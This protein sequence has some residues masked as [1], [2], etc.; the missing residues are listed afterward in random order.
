MLIV[1]IVATFDIE[2]VFLCSRILE[3]RLEDNIVLTKQRL[4]LAETF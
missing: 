4:V 1:G 3:E 2:R